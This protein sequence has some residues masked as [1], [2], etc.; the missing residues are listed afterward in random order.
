VL[1]AAELLKVHLQNLENTATK[2]RVN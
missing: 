1:A 2:R